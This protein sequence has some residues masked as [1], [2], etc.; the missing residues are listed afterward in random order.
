MN[1]KDFIK[2]YR[3]EINN[4]KFEEVYSLADKELS[5]AEVGK[6]TELLYKCGVDPLKYMSEVPDGYAY[7]SNISKID[8]PDGVTSIGDFAFEYCTSLTS[9]NIS[10][11]VK[12]IGGEAFS[13]CSKLTSITIGNGVTSIGNWAFDDCTSLKSITYKGSKNQWN[14]IDLERSWDVGSSL[15]MI[16]CTDGVIKLA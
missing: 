4:R 2:K 14:V 11:S 16:H 9:V 12:N 3:E 7:N 13:G 1:L 15:E 8:I 5:Y 10:N 6:L